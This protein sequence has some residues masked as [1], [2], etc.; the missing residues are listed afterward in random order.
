[1]KGPEAEYSFCL[2]NVD[3]LHLYLWSLSCVWDEGC[4]KLKRMRLFRNI[5]IGFIF[6]YRKLEHE[7]IHKIT[8]SVGKCYSRIKVVL[9]PNQYVHTPVYMC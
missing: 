9:K 1:M 4:F 5:G 3:M 7:N 2:P 6:L 8:L